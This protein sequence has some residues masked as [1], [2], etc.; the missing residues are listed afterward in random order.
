MQMAND[1]ERSLVSGGFS[2]APLSKTAVTVEGHAG[3]ARADGIRICRGGLKDEALEP[4]SSTVVAGDR[5]AMGTVLD[6]ELVDGVEVEAPG[7]IF[8][9]RCLLQ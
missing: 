4:L 6:E 2:L 9:L 3:G 1:R 7:G 8:S 5:W